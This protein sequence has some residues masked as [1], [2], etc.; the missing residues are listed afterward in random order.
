MSETRIPAISKTRLPDKE[1]HMIQ[2]LTGMVRDNT[3]SDVVMVYVG[4][5]VFLCFWVVVVS[6]L[7]ASNHTYFVEI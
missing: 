7:L 6:G 1:I 3:V 5:C 2:W 4:C